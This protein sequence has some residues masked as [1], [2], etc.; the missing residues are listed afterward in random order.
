M[1][2][3]LQERIPGG[4]P[5]GGERVGEVLRKHLPARPDLS[6]PPEPFRTIVGRALA[7]DPNHRPSRVYD[8]LPPGDA[9]VS[10]GVRFI[11]EG[12]VTPPT[13]PPAGARP[14]AAEPEDILRIE[15]EEP[16]FYIGPETRPPR[17]PSR[18]A[19][20]PRLRAGWASFRR[21]DRDRDPIRRVSPVGYPR[22]APEPSPILIPVAPAA[23]PPLPSRR[24]RVA[25]LATSMLWAAPLIALLSLPIAGMLGIEPAEAPQQLA[26]LIVMGLLGTWSLLT[27][28]KAFEGRS[29]DPATRRLISLGI[30]L[31]LATAS[32]AFDE[33][34]RLGPPSATSNDVMRQTVAW[35]D[36]QWSTLPWATT[37]TLAYFGALSL[38]GSWSALASR[39][40]KARFRIWP[41]L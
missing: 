5:F 22:S 39:D 27:A 32:I 28:G 40:R 17:A 8:L 29:L 21:G 3:I 2:W 10:P 36:P 15:A 37:E 7:K 20:P 30:G 6:K 38:V 16:V 23:P 26:Y 12:K 14:R 24:I 11:G 41:I 4:V 19:V 33:V 35:L 18:P 1:G 13:P 31:L 9:P 34:F 25:E